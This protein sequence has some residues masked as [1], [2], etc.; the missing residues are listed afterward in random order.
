MP[1]LGMV[2]SSS[3]SKCAVTMLMWGKVMRS[4]VH[5]VVLLLVPFGTVHLRAD[6]VVILGG[7]EGF[8][9]GLGNALEPRKYARRRRTTPCLEQF[10]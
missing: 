1:C 10:A 3:S 6:Q 7:N 4:S 9:V 8:D 2:L 5:L